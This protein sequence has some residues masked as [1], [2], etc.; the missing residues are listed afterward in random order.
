MKRL[1]SIAFTILVLPNVVYAQNC[2]AP[3]S[4]INAIERDIAFAQAAPLD[5]EKDEFEPA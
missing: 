4:R 5:V 3:G 1:I 2:P